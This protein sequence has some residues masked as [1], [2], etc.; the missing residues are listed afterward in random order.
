MFETI[1]PIALV[2]VIA[3]MAILPLIAVTATS[4]LKISAV[5]MILRNAIG[6][7]QVPSN[8]V[9]Y[10]VA[11]VMSL[12]VMGSVFKEAGN[13]FAPDGALPETGT[14]IIQAVDRA[15]P[16]FKA[17]MLQH[18]N[19]DYLDGFY[20]TALD[21]QRKYDSAPIA[22]TDL[23]IVLPAFVASEL[24]DAFM[25]GVL[26]YLPFVIIDLATSSALMAL[27]MMMVSPMS[28]TIPLKILLFVAIE[29]WSKVFNGLINSYMV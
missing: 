20:K 12:I 4:F 25:L 21:F 5:L 17:F 18:S 13:R 19:P 16:P 11:M 26:I 22:K 1:N 24:A 9:L 10:G 7:Q 14:E 8:M 29:G 6:V 23:F 3:S 27:G 28:I 2:M 15:L